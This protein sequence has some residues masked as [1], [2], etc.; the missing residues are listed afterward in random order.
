LKITKPFSFEEITGFKFGYHPF[1]KPSFFSHVYF[2]DG[3]LIDTGHIKV[4]KQVIEQLQSLPVKQ[5]FITHHH[6]DHTGNLT[7]LVDLFSCPAY[8]SEKCAQIMKNPPAISPAQK[9]TWGDRPAFHKLVPTKE[10]IETPNYR[11]Q[12][13]PIPG[14]AEDMVAL[15]EPEQRWLFSADLYVNHYISYFLPEESVAQQ[16][17]SINTILA[18]DFDILLCGHNPKFEGGKELLRKKRDFLNQF[19]DRVASLYQRGYNAKEIFKKLKF[20]EKGFIKWLSRGKLSRINMVKA[21]IRDIKNSGQI[22]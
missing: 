16:I 12:M 11:F 7:A 9:M 4:R 5:I 3:L 17:K 20:K 22:T 15:Y 18:L 8:A 19:Y 21:V 6:E 1:G 14:H 2:I 13:I 10:F